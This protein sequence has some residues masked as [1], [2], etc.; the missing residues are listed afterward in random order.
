VRWT[1]STLPNRRGDRRDRVDHLL[2]FVLDL[3]PKM[4][5]TFRDVLDR[6]P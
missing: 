5:R 4:F 2:P 3:P 6:I 1:I